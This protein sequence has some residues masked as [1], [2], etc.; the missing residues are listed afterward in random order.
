MQEA[1][2]VQAV[3][4]SVYGDNTTFYKCGFIGYQDTLFDSIGRHYY[5]DCYIQGEVDF[6]FGYARSFY[7]KCTINAT[8]RDNLPGYVT[9]HGRGQ[10]E[11]DPNGGFVFNRCAITGTGKVNLGRAWGPEARVIFQ[12]TYFGELITPQGWDA[13]NGQGHEDKLTFAEV[14][15]TGPGS[16]TNDRVPWEKK[17]SIS[18]TN[19]YS[20]S[21][22]INYD[23]WLDNLP[24]TH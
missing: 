20:Y 17:L 23:G 2:I 22:F 12:N 15:C 11:G 18:E 3:A 7:Q 10:P 1:Q 16:N 14:N 21:S 4:A 19:E 13:W 9:A 8:G 24:V 5:H 6:I